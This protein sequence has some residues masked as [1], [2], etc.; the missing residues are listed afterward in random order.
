MSCIPKTSWLFHQQT[1]RLQSLKHFTSSSTLA[2]Y[3]FVQ[4]AAGRLTSVQSPGSD[5]LSSFTYDVTNQLTGA[6][7]SGNVSNL[8]FSYDSNGNRNNGANVPGVDNRQ[9][10]DSES[11][12]QYDD[13]GNLIRQTNKSTGSVVEYT[14][15]VRNRLT[16]VSYRGTLNGSL[17]KGVH[18]G[19]DAINRRISRTLDSNGDG[20]AD[21]TEY[22]INYGQRASRENAGD[23]LALV[24]NGTGQVKTR[25]LH[26]ALV[27]EVLAEENVTS[28]TTRDVLWVL[29]DQ[30]GSVRDLARVTNGQV[31]LVDHIQYDAFGN[32][33]SETA[34]AVTHLFGYTGRESD[35]ETGLQYNR[36][37]YYAPKLGRFLGQDPLSFGA[38]DANLYR[39]VGN[40]ATNASDPSGLE[41]KPGEGGTA[42]ADR[43]YQ[44]YR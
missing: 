28:A 18:Y 5:G 19:Y 34:P 32:I 8:S 23:E 16:D 25:I 7:Y 42:V 9:Q 40:G 30:K 3:K 2:Q 44:G 31:Q 6:T 37:R 11:T 4:D 33:G 39:Y 41:E 12:F 10:S 38:G 14:F 15:D 36:A 24:L 17:T 1:D 21:I 29:P 13:N 43:G 26:G 35:K 22:F 20:V 27:D